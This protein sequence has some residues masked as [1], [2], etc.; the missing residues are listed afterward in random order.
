[1]RRPLTLLVAMVV[2]V[3]C[4]S[5]RTAISGDPRSTSEASPTA[6]PATPYDSP[7]ITFRY[8]SDW[9]VQHFMVMS[10][11]SSSLVYLSNQPMADP[12]VRQDSSNV[13]SITCQA[14]PV[15]SLEP[16]GIVVSWST[17][18]FPSWTFASQPGRLVTVD[19]RDAK[20]TTDLGGACGTLGADRALTVVISRKPADNWYQLDACLRD[21]G[22]AA[23]VA[24]ILALLDSVHISG[25][26]D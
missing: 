1:M 5:A 3:G 25:R 17:H 18:G 11:F 24:D 19:G 8:P 7:P 23:G 10:S 22:A 14:W 13:E 6:Q 9:T 4:T 26:A 16:G 20:M 21:P 15:Q 12:C 2:L